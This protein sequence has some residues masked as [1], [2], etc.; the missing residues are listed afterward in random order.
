MVRQNKSAATA[1]MKRRIRT[2]LAAF[3]IQMTRSCTRNTKMAFRPNMGQLTAFVVNSM[4]KIDMTGRTGT[5]RP[6]W[7]NTHKQKAGQGIKETHTGFRFCQF[8]EQFLHF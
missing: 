8:H 4:I 6:P 5:Q 2:V 1:K 7:T 3:M